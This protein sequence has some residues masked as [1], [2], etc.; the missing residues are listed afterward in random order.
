MDAISHAV[1]VAQSQPT[2]LDV[3]AVGKG[4][5]SKGGKGAKGGG[6]RDNQT[7]QACS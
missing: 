7:Q 4:T 5:S 2:A 1:A 6:K 3:G